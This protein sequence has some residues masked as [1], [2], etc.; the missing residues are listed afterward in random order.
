VPAAEA[1]GY[2]MNWSYGY[3]PIRQL[4]EGANTGTHVR[5]MI[6]G[7]RARGEKPAGI[8]E[9][10]EREGKPLQP[11]TAPG[12]RVSWVGRTLAGREAKRRTTPQQSKVNE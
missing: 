2:K 1:S 8:D 10:E 11:H 5:P 7:E 4:P 12:K 9:G 3:H 6:G